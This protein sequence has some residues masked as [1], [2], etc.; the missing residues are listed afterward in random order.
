MSCAGKNKIY[1]WQKIAKLEKTVG[2]ETFSGQILEALTTAVL[3]VTEN[4]RVRSDS[5]SSN[6]ILES[7]KVV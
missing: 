1:P 4:N 3:P 5:W 7:S 2:H 6:Q